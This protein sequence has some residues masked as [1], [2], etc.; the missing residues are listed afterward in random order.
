MASACRCWKHGTEAQKKKYLPR[1][2][3]GEILGAFCLTEPQ[4]G[5]D[6]ARIQARAVRQGNEYVLN[7]T[8]SWVTIGSDSGICIAFAKTDPQPARAA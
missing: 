1:L 4:A 5:S 3:R 2:A 6:A 8:K 7:G